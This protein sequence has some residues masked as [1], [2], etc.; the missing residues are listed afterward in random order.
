MGK[1]RFEVLP[2]YIAFIN[3]YN[4]LCILNLSFD[5]PVDIIL[6]VGG[7]IM[8]GPLLQGDMRDHGVFSR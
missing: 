4:S 7:N 6:W 3:E 1:H 5:F 2:L 8:Q